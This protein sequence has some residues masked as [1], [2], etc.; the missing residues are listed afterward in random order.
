MAQD[1]NKDQNKPER[2]RAEPEIIPPDRGQGQGWPPPPDGYARAGGARLYVTRIGPFGF[3]LMMLAV[4]LLAAVFLLLLIGTVLF[5][6][7]V[8]AALILIAVIAR[9]VRLLR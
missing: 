7:P 3:A 9:I 2:P 6:L 1:W 8:V 5:W 4:G